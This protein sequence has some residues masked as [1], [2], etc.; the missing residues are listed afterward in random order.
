MVALISGSIAQGVVILPS[1]PALSQALNG[2]PK[3]SAAEGDAMGLALLVGLNE[4]TPV[5]IDLPWA[6]L[7]IP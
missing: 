2:G 4:V 7:V 6:V 5:T 3:A 1:L